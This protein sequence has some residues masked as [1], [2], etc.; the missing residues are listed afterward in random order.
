MPSLATST[1]LPLQD[2]FMVIQRTGAG[3]DE[4]ENPF[5]YSNLCDEDLLPSRGYAHDIS[6]FQVKL[7]QSRQPAGHVLPLRDLLI[8]S[9][10]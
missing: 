6:S 2:F 4:K 3:D 8:K 1:E 5:V 7:A 10:P 9:P